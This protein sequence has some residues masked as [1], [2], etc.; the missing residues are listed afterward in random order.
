[1]QILSYLFYPNP[2]NAGYGS[3]KAILLLGICA[4]FVVG[5]PSWFVSG[6]DD[7]AIP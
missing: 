7:S 4:T 3:P 2:G 6:A 5:F 1:M